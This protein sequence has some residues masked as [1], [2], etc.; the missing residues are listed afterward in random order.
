MGR[1]GVEI[2]ARSPEELESLFEDAFMVRDAEALV[3]LFDEQAVVTPDGEQQQATGREEIAAL[4]SASWEAERAYLSEIKRIV[5]AGDIALVVLDWS[6]SSRGSA[7]AH[8][9][10][11]RGVDVLRRRADGTWRYLIALFDVGT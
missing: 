4:V 9:P 2:Q 3:E 7:G 11:A 5:V 8:D 6:L 1:I 10:S